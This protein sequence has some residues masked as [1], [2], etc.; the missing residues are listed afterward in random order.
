VDR[1]RFSAVAHGD[2]AIWNPVGEPALRRLADGL[3][4]PPAPRVLDVGCGPGALLVLLAARRG[5]SGVGVDPAAVPAARARRALAAAGA[6]GRIEIREEPFDAS[7]LAPASFDLAACVGSS[8]AVGDAAA[9]LASLAPLV[10]PGG[11]VLLGE[12]FWEREPDPGYLAFLDARREDYR[13]HAGTEALGREAGLVPLASEACSREDWDRYEDAYAAN[14]ERFVA[15]NP[16]DPDAAAMLARIRPWR[17]AYLRWGRDT[18][19]FGLYLSR[20]P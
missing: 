1:A 20:R 5:A 18:L 14:V 15:A 3:P 11:L 13:D 7:R 8:H 12:G 2:L 9:A 19:G 17:E 4:L 10:R 16:A 6:E